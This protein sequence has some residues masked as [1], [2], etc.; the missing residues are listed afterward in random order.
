MSAFKMNDGRVRPTSVTHPA[1]EADSRVSRKRTPDVSSQDEK[2]ALSGSAPPTDELA[3][4]Q[5]KF[6]GP[7]HQPLEHRIMFL[8]PII[9]LSALHRDP[10][11][12]SKTF[13][14]VGGV[15]GFLFRNCASRFRGRR[16]EVV[17]E[18]AHQ[19]LD[20]IV[21]FEIANLHN[22]GDGAAS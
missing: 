16:A 22:F 14:Q 10:H 11:F 19:A 18:M 12:G 9:S 7:D 6:V 2:G 20:H 1:P 13:A 4:A 17:H 8:G 3:R 21:V 15:G 5:S